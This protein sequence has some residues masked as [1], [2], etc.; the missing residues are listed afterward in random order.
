[1]FEIEFHRRLDGH[2]GSQRAGSQ[3]RMPACVPRLALDRGRSL[4]RDFLRHTRQRVV[5][6]QDAD[7]GRAGTVTG[8]ESRWHVG[9][10][11]TNGESSALELPSS[12]TRPSEVAKASIPPAS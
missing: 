6:G 7:N 12:P 4:G 1:M 8:Y 10:V 5:L 9:N 11:L 2:R 3:P